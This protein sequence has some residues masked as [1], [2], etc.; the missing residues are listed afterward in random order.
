MRVTL[1]AVWFEQQRTCDG[2][3]RPVWLGYVIDLSF[4]QQS[5]DD[6]DTR[7]AWLDV[8]IDLSFEQ[9]RIV[10]IVAPTV[11]E[12]TRSQHRLNSNKMTMKTRGQ[13][14]LPCHRTYRLSRNEF[15][16]PSRRSL[17]SAPQGSSTPLRQ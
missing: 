15:R 7:G 12:H 9:Q 5:T 14:D 13:H 1:V 11:D 3:S 4:E 2:D 6:G 17:A 8:T 10:V 16:F